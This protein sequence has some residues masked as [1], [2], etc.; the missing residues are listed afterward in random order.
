MQQAVTRAGNGKETPGKSRNPHLVEQSAKLGVVIA[1]HPYECAIQT[2][3]V[4]ELV[5][6][7]KSLQRIGQLCTIEILFRAAGPRPPGKHRLCIPARHQRVPGLRAKRR[8]PR[9]VRFFPCDA[10]LVALK[11][12]RITGQQERP[13]PAGRF[14][15]HPSQRKA[16]AERIAGKPRFLRKSW[17]GTKIRSSGREQ[18]RTSPIAIRL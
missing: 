3:G 7:G 5:R 17:R 12:A 2:R 6:D 1:R 9:R 18:I 10:L 16:R 13:V 8:C 14:L 4:G 15:R 11:I